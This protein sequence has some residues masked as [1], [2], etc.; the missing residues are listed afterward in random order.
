[1]ATDRF[2]RLIA[3]LVGEVL[4]RW[5][6][7]LLEHGE[8]CHMA[9]QGK[10]TP[11]STQNQLEPNQ[12]WVM[13]L[14]KYLPP[15]GIH[16][17]LLLGHIVCLNNRQCRDELN[18][19]FFFEEYNLGRNADTFG[20]SLSQNKWQNQKDP[21]P[22]KLWAVISHSPVAGSSGH[23]GCHCLLNWNLPIIKHHL[24]K[25][26][27]SKLTEAPRGR[28]WWLV[29]FLQ[30]ETKAQLR[31]GV[32]YACLLSIVRLS[33][34][35]QTVWGVSPVS[36]ENSRMHYGISCSLMRVELTDLSGDRPVATLHRVSAAPG[37]RV[38]TALHGSAFK[39][40]CMILMKMNR[41]CLCWESPTKSHLWSST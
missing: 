34:L 13:A 31:Q 38:T 6:A 16:Y 30:V 26:P 28:C 14:T 41:Q 11:K 37:W 29:D 8:T 24:L 9:T 25:I 17:V 3:G 1:M 36:T 40:L 5:A 23:G 18:G 10:L 2:Q 32:E 4:A 39:Y 20:A 15:K 21:A 12:P 33:M 35:I 7:E 22:L 27:C 19:F